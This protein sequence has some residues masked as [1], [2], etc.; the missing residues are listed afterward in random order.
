MQLYPSALGDLRGLSPDRMQKLRCLIGHLPFGIHEYL[1]DPVDYVTILRHPVDRFLSKY[2]YLRNNKWVSDQI[3][4][5]EKQL[6]SLDA[7]ID[8]QLERNATNVQTR[9]ISGCVDFSNPVP[10]FREPVPVE[11][12]DRA[13]DN[14]ENQFAVVGLQERFDESLLLMKHAFGWKDIA[15][16]RRNLTP[17][18]FK[19]QE[20]LPHVRARIEGSNE[21]DM[22]LYEF[23]QDLFARRLSQYDPGLEKELK[24]LKRKNLRKAQWSRIRLRATKL[25]QRAGRR[26][27]LRSQ[28]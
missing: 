10:P 25:V 13:M 20:T 5:D 22:Q 26:L 6:A 8:A 19:E 18:R 14:L 1:P 16:D 21:L 4:L 17:R 28:P 11:M 27:N 24:A 7:Y 3:G 9:Q 23:A 2:G 15:Y 12:L